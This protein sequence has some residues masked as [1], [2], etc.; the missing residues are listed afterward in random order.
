MK[1]GTEP[2]ASFLPVSAAIYIS[3]QVSQ[4]FL[5]KYLT[6]CVGTPPFSFVESSQDF[7]FQNLLICECCLLSLTSSLSDFSGLKKE[8][9]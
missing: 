2:E 3:A 8:D 4:Q 1:L 9:L 5:A 6:V 7:H